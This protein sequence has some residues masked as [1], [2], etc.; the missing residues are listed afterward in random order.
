MTPTNF[1][2]W[3]RK[4]NAVVLYKINWQLQVVTEVISAK[5]SSTFQDAWEYM[6]IYTI[7]IF[8]PH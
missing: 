7:D 4:K 8:S 5:S 2:L 3:I 6:Q 1:L